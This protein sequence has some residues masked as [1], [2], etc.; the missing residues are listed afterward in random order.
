MF[1]KTIIINAFSEIID[2]DKENHLCINIHI[3]NS[4][5]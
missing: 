1:F 2:C 3:L 5:K 4:S